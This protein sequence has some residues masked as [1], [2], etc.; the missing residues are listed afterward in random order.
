ME[1]MEAL[2]RF[3]NSHHAS[4]KFVLINTKNA[5]VWLPRP[6]QEHNPCT[7]QKQR[8]LPEHVF[9]DLVWRTAASL[10]ADDKQ[11]LHSHSQ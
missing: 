7:G 8:Q 9:L 4:D 5:P 2:A 10:N 3:D 1:A 11:K 6:R